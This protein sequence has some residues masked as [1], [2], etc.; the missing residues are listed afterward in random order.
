MSDIPAARQIV[1]EVRQRL[2]A[3]TIEPQD[4]VAK[5]LRAEQM[6]HR[7][8]MAYPRAPI[9]AEPLTPDTAAR[10]RRYKAR[11]P[12]KALLEIALRFETG[13]GRVSEAI[14]G[15]R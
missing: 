10:I 8:K 14:H 3:G 1:D 5:L 6:M 15:K 7:A 12:K 2:E 11:H 9:D 13:I 4:A